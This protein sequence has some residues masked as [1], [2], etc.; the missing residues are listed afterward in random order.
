MTLFLAQFKFEAIPVDLAHRVNLSNIIGI[1]ATVLIFWGTMRTSKA[2]RKGQ[3][4]EFTQFAFSKGFTFDRGGQMVAPMR[5]MDPLFDLSLDSLV[6][7]GPLLG[8]QQINPLLLEFGQQFRRFEWSAMSEVRDETPPYVQSV[9][10][11]RDADGVTWTIFQHVQPNRS[12]HWCL[13]AESPVLLPIL[14]MSPETASDRAAKSMGKRELQ[15]ENQ[16][17]NNR[18]FLETQEPDRVLHLLHPQAID[19]LMYLI[20]AEWE[21]SPRYIMVCLDGTASSQNLE[22]YYN[23]IKD[24]IRLI[25]GYYRKDFGFPNLS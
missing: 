3:S 17:F 9:M 15:V 1:V 16:A 22:T 19:R 13:I 21:F 7:S 2:L 12:V 20:P 10:R 25:P 5:R 8:S 11:G 18:Y 4:D 14:K 24:F 6:G 23:A